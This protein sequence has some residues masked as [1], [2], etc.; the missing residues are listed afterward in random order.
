MYRFTLR[1]G[2]KWHDGRDFTADDVKFSFDKALLPLH[3]RTKAS[4]GSAGLQVNVIDPRTVE[5]RFPNPYA[6]LLQQL[7]VTEAPIIPKHV[8]EG[9]ADISTVAG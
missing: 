6:P 2:V 4:M 8:Y 7:N 3:S 9:C 1:S 5:F